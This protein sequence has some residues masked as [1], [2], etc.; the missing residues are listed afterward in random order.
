MRVRLSWSRGLAGGSPGCSSCSG[1]SSFRLRIAVFSRPGGIRPSV[2]SSGSKR[3]A[4][5]MRPRAVEGVGFARLAHVGDREDAGELLLGPHAEARGRQSTAPLVDFDR[6]GDEHGWAFGPLAERCLAGKG[7]GGG[8]LTVERLVEEQIIGTRGARVPTSCG[9]RRGQ[10][11]FVRGDDDV[12]EIVLGFHER[13]QVKLQGRGGAA[14]WPGPARWCW[15]SLARAASSAMA[16]WMRMSEAKDLASYCRSVNQRRRALMSAC[17]TVCRRA[18]SSARVVSSTR[19]RT[20]R[21][22]RLKTRAPSSGTAHKCFES[23]RGALIANRASVVVREPVPSV[24]T[25]KTV[26]A[27]AL[28]NGDQRWAGLSGPGG[29]R[30][31]DSHGLCRLSRL[32]RFT[33][34]A[35]GFRWGQLRP[36]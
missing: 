15:R 32:S 8:Q 4:V 20:H 2:L 13:L 21:P 18:A 22:T 16:A 35:F 9:W 23:T 14:N 29:S 31:R 24:V 36:T 12:V 3:V 26:S 7:P 17:R 34:G 25:V 11:L 27:A 10:D 19:L 6:R 1:S 5:S 33:P 28:V 30:V